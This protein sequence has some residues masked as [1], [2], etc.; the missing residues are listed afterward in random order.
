[1]A[2]F[3][4]GLFCPVS[5]GLRYIG[6]SMNPQKR[7]SAHVSAA[8]RGATDHHHARWIRKLAESNLKPDLRI[9]HEVQPGERWQEVE[10]HL[11][12]DALGR[13]ISLTNSTAGGEGLDYVNEDDRARYLAN[14]AKAMAKYRATDA[15]KRQIAAFQAA[16]LSPENI[17]RRS[18]SIRAAYQSE[19]LRQRISETSKRTGALPYVKEA[20]SKATSAL[21]ADETYREKKLAQLKSEEFRAAQSARIA[22]RWAD[23]EAKARLKASRWTEEARKA[24]ADRI[25]ARNQ[26][27]AGQVGAGK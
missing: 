1:M 13:G 14:K 9:L 4:Y 23:P 3:I 21:W 8:I 19:D 2:V 18:E 20:K 17:V 22:A 15:G 10:R 26:K 11:I 24:Q 6:K 7:L 25:R 5:G 16:S 12:S 27:A